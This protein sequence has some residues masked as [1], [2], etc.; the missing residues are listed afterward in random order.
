VFDGPAAN[1]VP[2]RGSDGRELVSHCARR[3]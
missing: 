1:E 3:A 2:D